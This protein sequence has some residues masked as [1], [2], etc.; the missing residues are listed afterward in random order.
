MKWEDTKF[1]RPVE[2][3]FSP[4]ES[5]SDVQNAVEVAHMY[6][7]EYW[8]CAMADGT[9]SSHEGIAGGPFKDKSP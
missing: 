8:I 6:K 1:H 9:K 7:T 3:L 5:A 2:N 4:S